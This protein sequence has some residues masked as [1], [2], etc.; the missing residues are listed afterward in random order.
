MAHHDDIESSSIARGRAAELGAFGGIGISWSWLILFFGGEIFVI[1]ERDECQSWTSGAQR[2]ALDI[3]RLHF[4]R[5]QQRCDA[6]AAAGPLFWVGS[7]ECV[8]GTR[9]HIYLIWE[10]YIRIAQ[11]VPPWH[12][13]LNASRR[14]KSF[15]RCMATAFVYLRPF[16]GGLTA[17]GLVQMS[18]VIKR[19]QFISK[20]K[21]HNHQITKIKKIIIIIE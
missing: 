16:N 9:I 4:Q 11:T 20:E 7:R 19:R 14:L 17:A 1:L 15:E 10:L 2:A 21:Q 18:T 6:A 12:Q 3:Y 13:T 8:T 5:Q